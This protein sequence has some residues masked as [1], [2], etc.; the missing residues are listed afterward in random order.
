MPSGVAVG[1]IGHER[2]CEFILYSQDFQ[3]MT[4]SFESI[5]CAQRDHSYCYFKGNVLR[6][7]IET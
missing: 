7:E 1:W 5:Q 2:N 3:S 4:L 6:L